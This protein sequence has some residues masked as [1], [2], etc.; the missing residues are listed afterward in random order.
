M[1]EQPNRDGDRPS[2]EMAEISRTMVKL[3]KDHFGR[4][5][6]KAYSTWVGEDILVCILEDSLTPAEKTLRSLG[7]HQ[8]LRDIRTFFQ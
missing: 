3:Y 1:I 6:T 2:V 7:E 5:P 8:R 4:G